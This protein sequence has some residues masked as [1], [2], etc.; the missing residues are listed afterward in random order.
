[1]RI[2]KR[3]AGGVTF[4]KGATTSKVTTSDIRNAGDDGLATWADSVADAN[5]SF[6]HNTVQYPI[7]ANGIAIYG[8]HD[9]FVTDNR[10]IDAG[11]SQGGG[12][13]VAQRFAS[14]TL[15][16]T[17]VLRNTII[18]SGNL[19]PNWNFGVGALWF[20][21]RDGGMTGLTNVDNLLI[22]QSPYEAIHFVSG[23]NISTVKINNARIQNTGSYVVQE[24]VGGAA[25][26]S[27]STAT[28]T[29]GPFSIYNCGVGF[30]L[31]DGGGNSG[32]FT[33]TGCDANYVPTFP[34]YLPDNGSAISVSPSALG[35]GPVATGASSAAHP[36]TVTNSGSPAAPVT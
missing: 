30:T 1:M 29:Q 15:G 31:T 26:I 5:D 18:R 21:A 16:R 27:N 23:S 28:G 32:V 11:L 2:R 20:D 9:N 17:D 35:F 25:T 34:P 3:T 13:H 4:H 6:D 8:G 12:I 10:G 22:Q 19:D 24:Q 7:L 14:T 33:S 36:V